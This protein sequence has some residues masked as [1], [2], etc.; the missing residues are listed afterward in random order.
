MGFLTGAYGKLIAGQHLRDL[1]NRLTQVTRQHRIM[2]REIS[3]KEKNYRTYERNIKQGLQAQ[4]QQKI[5]GGLAG[6]LGVDPQTI[7]MSNS[8]SMYNMFGNMSKDQ[9]TNYAN[10][11]QMAQYEF[12]QAQTIWQNLFESQRD[13]DLEAL[14]DIQDDLETEKESLESQIKVAQA[15]YDAKKEEE[16][17]GA[18]NIAPDYTGQG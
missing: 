10:V 17:A 16:K 7:N 11:Q 18:K 6:A 15:E 2:T 5:W 4:M 13:Q 8:E 14:K 9:M 3:N 12:A 1:Q